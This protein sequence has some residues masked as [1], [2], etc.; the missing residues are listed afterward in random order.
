MVWGP[1][2]ARNRLLNDLVETEDFKKFLQY[3]V[4]ESKDDKDTTSKVTPEAIV[5]QLKLKERL[6]IKKRFRTFDAELKR[7]S[8]GAGGLIRGISGGLADDNIVKYGNNNKVA[9]RKFSSET[10]Q[11][12]VTKVNPLDIEYNAWYEERLTASLASSLGSLW[13][14]RFYVW[15]GIYSTLEAIFIT[16]AAIHAAQKD[17]STAE[18]AKFI[19]EGSFIAG[20][21]TVFVPI[22]LGLWCAWNLIDAFAQ[23]ADAYKDYKNGDKKLALTNAFSATLV[24][25]GTGITAA[26]MYGGLGAVGGMTGFGFGP[27]SFACCMFF[28]ALAAHFELTAL[29]EIKIS[30]NDTLQDL[31]DGAVAEQAFERIKKIIIELGIAPDDSKDPLKQQKFD[32]ALMSL[33]VT[34]VRAILDAQIK[35]KTTARF[36]WG[37]CALAMSAVAIMLIT[38]VGAAVFLTNPIGLAIIGAIVVLGLIATIGTRLYLRHQ[39]AVAKNEIIS[40]LGAKPG[41]LDT[42]VQKKYVEATT[43]KSTVNANKTVSTAS[44]ATAST[45]STHSATALPLN[46]QQS[47]H[48]SNHH[49]ANNVQKRSTKTPPTSPTSAWNMAQYGRGVWHLF[50]GNGADLANQTHPIVKFK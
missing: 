40:I 34:E 25:I 47:N 13:I 36:V 23:Y 3:A 29:K 37:S 45:A 27:I 22:T 10:A 1:N 11:T 17:V 50:T 41:A 35:L 46:F 49:G 15:G 26:V 12:N 39:E 48:R 31:T 44:T 18:L 24:L 2:F 16:M 32:Q 14:H 42:E 7:D 38:T 5:K 6:E 28:T 9:F 20:V 30:G 19:V 4:V 21:F 8:M 33:S 43:P